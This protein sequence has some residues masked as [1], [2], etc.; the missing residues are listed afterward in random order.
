MNGWTGFL[1]GLPA[2]GVAVYYL[3]AEHFAAKI[4]AKVQTTGK[5]A[6]RKAAAV[7]HDAQAAAGNVA[8]AAKDA[9]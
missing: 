2:G 5:I 1:L 8:Q 3:F 7:A 4:V 9:V 6:K